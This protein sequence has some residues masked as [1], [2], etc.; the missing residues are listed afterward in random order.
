MP[1]QQVALEYPRRHARFADRAEQ[2][3]VERAHVFQR[4][5]GEHVAGLEE[6]ARAEVVVDLLEVDAAGAQRFQPL[7]DDLW[8]DPVPRDDTDAVGHGTTAI[9]SRIVLAS[10]SSPPTDTRPS[11]ISSEG[12][13]RPPIRSRNASKSAV[14]VTLGSGMGSVVRPFP[15]VTVTANERPGAATLNATDCPSGTELSHFEN[16]GIEFDAIRSN[17]MR[18]TAPFRCP[19]F[20]VARRISCSWKKKSV[21]RTGRNRIQGMSL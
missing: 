6:A 13:R 18:A 12:G 7:G 3:G 2:D 17:T 19:G 9:C 1:Q 20:A 10:S 5:V 11:A 16:R 4:L 15:S 21:T 14:N 8:P